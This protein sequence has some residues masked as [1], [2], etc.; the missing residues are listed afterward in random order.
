MKQ[1]TAAP[2][3]A[4]L[5][6]LRRLNGLLARARRRMMRR[7]DLLFYVRRF[8]YVAREVAALESL[9]LLSIPLAHDE[10][11]YALSR[12]ASTTC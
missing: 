10:A 9:L 3:T 7:P 12:P 2:E 6:E 1:V 11:V 8:L 5:R 4:I